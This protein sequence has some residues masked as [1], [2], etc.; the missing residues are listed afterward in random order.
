M[1]STQQAHRNGLVAAQVSIRWRIKRIPSQ[2]Y[3]HLVLNDTL[4]MMSVIRVSKCRCVARK[5]SG[6]NKF[7][8][9]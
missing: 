3:L 8:Q 4:S 5:S 9:S 2:V 6:H 1:M 7:C